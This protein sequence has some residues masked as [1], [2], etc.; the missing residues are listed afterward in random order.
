MTVINQQ[1]NNMKK[2]EETKLNAAAAEFVP[3]TVLGGSG[4]P[5]RVGYVGTSKEELQ[6]DVLNVIRA[7]GMTGIRV[8]QIPHQYRRRTGR[9][10]VIEGTAYPSLSA[11]IDDIMA[12]IEF[13]DAPK[14]PTPAG[15]Q[16]PNTTDNGMVVMEP[17]P[18]IEGAETCPP[19]VIGQYANKVVRDK[20]FAANTEDLSFFK[21]LV[22]A[23]VRDFCDRD[24]H[25]TPSGLL[26]QSSGL[27]LSLFSAEWDRYFRGALSLKGMR[28]KFGVMKLLPFIL[29]CKELEMLGT[30]P[31]V[32]IRV[33]EE[34]TIPA[35]LVKRTTI[36]TSGSEGLRSALP[37]VTAPPPPPPP[38][39][40]PGYPPPSDVLSD[41]LMAAAVEAVLASSSA[42]PVVAG[43]TAPL[44]P[45]SEMVPLAAAAAAAEVVTLTPMESAPGFEVPLETVSPVDLSPTSCDSHEAGKEEELIPLPAIPICKKDLKQL[46]ATVIQGY[47]IEQAHGWDKKEDY[48]LAFQKA[49]ADKGYDAS[50]DTEHDSRCSSSSS[51][52]DEGE[53]N[54]MDGGIYRKT[55]RF[56]SM[57]AELGFKLPEAWITPKLLSKVQ[58]KRTK[59]I[60]VKVT[61][62]RRLWRRVYPGLNPLDFYLQIVNVRKLRS[63]LADM[64]DMVL[65]GH[66]S[67][68]R[69]APREHV[70]Q[71]CP[72]IIQM[73]EFSVPPTAAASPMP[74]SAMDN[75]DTE[76]AQL[77][78]GGGE[79]DEVIE[80]LIKDLLLTTDAMTSAELEVEMA[81]A[82]EMEPASSGQQQSVAA[83]AVGSKKTSSSRFR[84]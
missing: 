2:R 23:V 41:Y 36:K 35:Q 32:R 47:C 29:S 48:L 20:S 22:V 74:W 39:A 53:S 40:P 51:G 31:E 25:R 38:V 9:W 56:N 43:N 67:S 78:A 76:P 7:T 77:A 65:L 71:Y 33:K 34:Y 13:Y 49:L 16:K 79:Q 21:E 75:G 60:G 30:H 17:T 72:R 69:V 73:S 68:M 42:P 8:T 6:S 82:F 64:G 66:G 52:E 81:R 83:S 58:T 61:A 4:P 24:S 12:S 46:V 27:A 70:L 59:T 57:M 26:T 14:A 19:L 37:P 45:P 44:P 50:G 54:F 63:L 28:A 62:V 55:S 18:G 80:K 3:S 15:M 1:C 84:E 11:I 10:L 5:P